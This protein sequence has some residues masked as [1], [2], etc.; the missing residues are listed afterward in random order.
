M[1]LEDEGIVI[2]AY[3]IIVA[4]SHH[5]HVIIVDVVLCLIQLFEQVV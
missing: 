3:L 5:H 4:S 2:P 1:W